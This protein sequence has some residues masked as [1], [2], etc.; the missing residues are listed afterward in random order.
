M[1]KVL[2]GTPHFGDQWKCE[3]ISGVFGFPYKNY[4]DN[5]QGF[6]QGGGGGEFAPLAKMSE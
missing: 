5:R 3:S 2:S 4:P 1:S 6:I